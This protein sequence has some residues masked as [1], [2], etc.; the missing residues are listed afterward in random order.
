MT[1]VIF[2][3]TLQEV[4]QVLNCR[5]CFDGLLTSFS[6]PPAKDPLG[7]LPASNTSHHLRLLDLHRHV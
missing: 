1:T 5:G 3:Y 6:K 7:T 2:R 4:S